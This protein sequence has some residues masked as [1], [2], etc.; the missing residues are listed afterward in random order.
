MISY[1]ELLH[2]HNIAEVPMVHQQNLQDLLAKINTVRSA[3][4]K[5][6][7]VTSGYRSMQD[8]IRIYSKKGQVSHIPM[9]SA[10]LKGC[11]VDIYDPDGNLQKWLKANPGILEAAGLWCEDGTTNWV[12]FQTYAPKSGKRW[13]LP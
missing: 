11:A 5:P 12:H 1:K 2:G 4:N 8:Q 3:W 6:M 7:I 13:F 9:K 10:H